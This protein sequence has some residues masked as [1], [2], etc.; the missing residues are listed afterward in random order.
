ML[1]SWALAAAAT[2]DAQQVQVS[3]LANVAFGT[4]ANFSV[5]LVRSQSICVYSSAANGRYQVTATGNG[6]GGAFT[7]AS[8]SNLLAYEVQWSASS[9]QATGTALRPGVAL[10]GQT[11]IATQNKCGSGAAA[12]ASLIALIRASQISA[13]T[14]GQYRGTLTLLIAPN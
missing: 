1:A 12:S 3:G 4:V 7:L 6:A 10:A 11:S 14:A 13:A 5:D 2:A 8:G 9:G